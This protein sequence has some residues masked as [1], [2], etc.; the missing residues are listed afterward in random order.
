MEIKIKLLT[1]HTKGRDI[2][3]NEGGKMGGG[4]YRAKLKD[5]VADEHYMGQAEVRALCQTSCHKVC[6][7][8]CTISIQF[9]PY[10]CSHLD[11]FRDVAPSP[12]VYHS[13]SYM[14]LYAVILL[15][16]LVCSSPPVGLDATKQTVALDQLEY[17]M[18]MQEVTLNVR[19]KS[20]LFMTLL[21]R[22]WLILS[23]AVLDLTLALFVSAAQAIEHRLLK[24]DHTAIHP[25]LLDMRIGQGRHQQGYFPKLQAD[26][27]AQGQNTNKWALLFAVFQWEYI[28]TVIL[29]HEQDHT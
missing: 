17:K 13:V 3:W 15:Y 6:R 29:K 11:C 8:L 26:V 4:L 9:G 14:W 25:H 1:E 21:L 16:L 28:R 19:H 27:L 7:S 23:T 10:N 5:M 18:F 24:A 12:F 22:W 20:S 2:I